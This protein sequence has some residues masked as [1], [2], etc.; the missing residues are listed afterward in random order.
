MGRGESSDSFATH[1]HLKRVGAPEGP[2]FLLRDARA[3]HEERTQLS[4]RSRTRRRSAVISLSSCVL[5]EAAG[6]L[7][8]QLKVR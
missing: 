4:A 8:K 7:K 2:V 5:P 6:D 3:L 1:H